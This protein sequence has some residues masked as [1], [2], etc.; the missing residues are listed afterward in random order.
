VEFVH[1]LES[2][3]AFLTWNT[4][5]CVTRYL[6]T[7]LV[8]L[9]SPLPCLSNNSLLCWTSGHYSFAPALHLPRAIK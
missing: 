9:E 8:S 6:V 5:V 2:Q 1:L 3:A 7:N 4:E